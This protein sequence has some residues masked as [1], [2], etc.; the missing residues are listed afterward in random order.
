MIAV[1]FQYWLSPIALTMLATHDGPLSEP[2]PG[3]SESA[4]SGTTQDICAN[5]P[6]EMSVRMVVW[7]EITFAFHSGPWRTG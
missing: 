5:L 1:E 3:W 6:L 7:G 4:L 2:L